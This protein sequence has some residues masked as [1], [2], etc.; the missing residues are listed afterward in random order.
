MDFM[1]LAWFRFW[2]MK[3]IYAGVGVCI[4]KVM[5]IEKD[6]G[7]ILWYLE[8][9]SSVGNPRSVVWS[10]NGDKYFVFF[11]VASLLTLGDEVEN[12]NEMVSSPSSIPFSSLVLVQHHCIYKFSMRAVE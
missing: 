4:L 9:N 10:E 7:P 5:G 3:C 11:N 6:E 8:T 12:Q 2:S 1:F